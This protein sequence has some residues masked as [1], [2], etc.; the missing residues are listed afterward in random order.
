MFVLFIVVFLVI[1][2]IIP[3]EAIHPSDITFEIEGRIIT[4]NVNELGAIDSLTLRTQDG[5]AIIDIISARVIT[6]SGKFSKHRL[7]PDMKVY[8]SLSEVTPLVAKVVV[9]DIND[10]RQVNH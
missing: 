4:V 7:Q 3:A 2:A 8:I 6:M 9:V 5:D 1:L 10:Y